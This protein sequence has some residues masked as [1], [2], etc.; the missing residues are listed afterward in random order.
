MHPP[1]PEV[2]LRAL[3]DD[4]LDLLERW[5]QVPD[6][7]AFLDDDTPPSRARIRA[8]LLARRLDVLI[9]DTAEEPVGFFLV[10]PRRRGGVREFDIAIPETR[11]RQGG[12]AKAAIAAFER[13]AFDAQKLTAVHANIFPENRPCL[14]LVR[15]CAWPLSPVDPGGIEFRGKPRD[16]VYTHMNEKLLPGA[17]SKR[18]F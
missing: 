17:R 1:L 7:F 6:V 9:I 5:V 10:Y 12:V 15:A 13:W 4:D 2:T 14:E 16:V 8:E 11:A 18:G 3:R